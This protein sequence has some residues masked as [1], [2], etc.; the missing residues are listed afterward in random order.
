MT[1][2]AQTRCAF[3]GKEVQHGK[4][5]HALV[6]CATLHFDRVAFLSV[7]AGGRVPSNVLCGFVCGVSSD[8]VGVRVALDIRAG[9]K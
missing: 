4:H 6:H 5:H 1:E 8:T 2:L 3:S 7:S 9:F